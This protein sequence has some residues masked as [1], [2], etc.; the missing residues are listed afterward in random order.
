[1]RDLCL[2]GRSSVTRSKYY[3]VVANPRVVRDEIAWCE[4]FALQEG[5][6]QHCRV[7]PNTLVVLHD[8]LP[9]CLLT[10]KGLRSPSLS[11][12]LER[13]FILTW[14]RRHPFSEGTASSL[15]DRR[16]TRA[17]RRGWW[18][19]T[20]A[21]SHTLPHRAVERTL[22]ASAVGRA[23]RIARDL[24][25]ARTHSLTGSAAASLGHEPW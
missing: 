12:T 22:G 5:V 13:K 6:L 10:R 9:S 1:M 15:T 3:G 18:H 25:L 21:R 23:E 14:H 11:L 16:L 2:A 17:I 7:L 8:S 4:T 19:G 20:L 24:C